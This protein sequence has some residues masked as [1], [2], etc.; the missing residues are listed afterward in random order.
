M[1]H[2]I[3]PSAPSLLTSLLF[4]ILLAGGSAFAQVPPP[5]PGKPDLGKLSPLAEAPDWTKLEALSKTMSAADFDA[6]FEGTYSNGKNSPPPWQRD[7]LGITVPTGAP[8][9]RVVRIEFLPPGEKPGK[10]TRYWHAASE[11]PP[12]QG[13]P[14]LSGL[15]IALDP[16]HIGGSYAKMEERYLTFHPDKPGEV[17]MEGEHVLVVAQ[18]LKAR[19]EALGAR[20][21][22]VREKNE[23]VSTH[24]PA[25]YRNIAMQVLRENGILTPKD[26]YAGLGNAE[27]VM[28][29]QWQSEKLFYRTAEINARAKLVNE[30]LKPDLVI[31]LHLNAAPW[32]DPANPSPTPENHMHLLING[33]YL[34]DELL[35]QDER[36]GMLH[37][38][39]TRTHDEELPLAE[40]VSDSLAARTGLKPFVYTTP[41]ARLATAN[42]YVYARNLLA[43]RIYDC[44]VIYA[45][46]Y[47]M[48]NQETYDRL[49][50][51]AYSGRTLV[52][53]KLRPSIFHEY[54]DG[55]L[56]GVVNYYRS[57]RK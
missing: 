2:R 4:A 9:G 30:Q 42:G 55:V 51:G 18:L 15:H 43:N 32:G 26:S 56:D 40:A 53:G 1:I 28:T 27:K 21:S 19:L 12:L 3:M 50:L 46:P 57:K 41:N 44:P 20:V 6:V 16:G 5:A 38:L 23:P 10:V 45:E 37:R 31:C 35:L 48:N 34:P 22:L 11:L 54:A 24:Q 14:P 29:I 39:L 33:C 13:K 8:D 36:F 17:V 49:V 25:E 7:P 52:G 47:V